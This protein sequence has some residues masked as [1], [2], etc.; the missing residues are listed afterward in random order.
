MPSL[1]ERLK[2]HAHQLGF[3]LVGITPANPAPTHSSFLDWLNQGYAGEMNYLGKQKQARSNPE[4]VLPG[5]K[6]IMALGI[7]YHQPDLRNKAIPPAHG[8]IASYALG[9]D[10][11]QVL[12]DKLNSLADWLKQ[13]KPAASTRGIVDTAPLLE[14][15]YARM[16]GLG[17]FGKNTMLINKHFG[18]FFFI[19]S[20]L[21]D[22]ELDYD[23]P[24][25]QSHCGTCTACLDA[26]PTQAFP[27]PGKLDA[28]R[29]ISY[30]TIELRGPV[31]DQHKKE[32]NHWLFG[33]DVCQD[34]CPWNRKAPSGKEP[35][36][37]ADL[38]LQSGTV[39]LLELFT[40]SPE[41][42]RERFRHTA[43]WRAKRNGLLRNACL[44]L[45][46]EM[47]KAAYSLLKQAMQD[48]DAGVRDA[49]TW[50]CR[51][52]EETLY[53]KTACSSEAG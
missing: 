48:E 17:W 26:C 44:V 37:L 16:A 21:T 11:H 5:V 18:S 19:A 31:P 10:Y 14:R 46:N 36:L 25:L 2:N 39:S 47:N 51:R 28:T 32:I 33:C 1:S 49:A 22:L 23:Q 27:E 3:E 53:D 52:M 12:W 42:W 45:G 43:L 34:V 50:A 38:H 35:A 6:T 24:H 41:Q 29:C 9:T 4:S 13:Q 15:D 7:S 40:Y 8:K 30:L 20:L